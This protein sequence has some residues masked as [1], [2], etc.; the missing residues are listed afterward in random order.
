[1]LLCHPAGHDGGLQLR[2][3][4]RLAQQGRSR[5]GGVTQ[6][7]TDETGTREKRTL[8]AAA[9]FRSA[10]CAGVSRLRPCM[11]AATG[12]EVP[13]QH[14]AETLPPLPPRRAAPNVLQHCG[15]GQNTGL[16]A[17]TQQ[18]TAAH[19]SAAQYKDRILCLPP[20]TLGAASRRHTRSVQFTRLAT[21]HEVPGVRR[22]GKVRRGVAQALQ[23]GA[24]W[25]L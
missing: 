20:T 17:T 1:M 10:V 22:A 13:R 4:S 8:G 6:K 3:Q 24:S 15:R 14:A 2:V 23:T 5:G 25:T 21:R 9:S 7:G 16:N 12:R 19:S 18:S 11:P